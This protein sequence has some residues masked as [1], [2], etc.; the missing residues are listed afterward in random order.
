M[1]DRLGSVPIF[2]TDQER[3][4]AFYRDTLGFEVVMDIPIG[5]SLRWIAVAPYKGGTEIILFHPDI[6]GHRAK[7]LAK[8]VGAFTGIVLLTND[9]HKT[10][11]E[12]CA[13]GVSCESE[14]VQQA[15]GG[16]ETWFSDPDGNRFHLAQR[17]SWMY[18]E[19]SP[20]S[21]DAMRQ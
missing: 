3:A 5:G 2:V 19:H 8:R 7:E 1:I 10:Y 6:G 17:P 13:H 14:P 15:W 21:L 18:E 4:L 20:A 9:I 16:L 12:L 11:A